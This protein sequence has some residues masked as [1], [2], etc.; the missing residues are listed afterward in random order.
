MEK[1]KIHITTFIKAPPKKV[2]ETMFGDATYREWTKA[3]MPGSYFKGTWETGSK[4]LF[5]GPN[6]ETGKEG[7][8]VS[9]IAEARPHEYVS[10]EHLGII[11]DG[12]ED[13]TSDFAKKWAPAYENYTFTEKDG[14]TEFTLDMEV[15]PEEKEMMEK[16]WQEALR[17]LKALAEK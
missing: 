17:S 1:Q 14:G 10:I 5:L 9:R 13:M 6:P 8:M 12:V 16:M 3:F 2:W 15:V 4:M 11:A 7:G